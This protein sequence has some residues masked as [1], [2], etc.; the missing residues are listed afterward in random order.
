VFVTVTDA[1]NRLVANLERAD[2]RLL[3]NGAAQSITVFDNGPR[4]LRLVL[5][6]DVSASMA[7]NLTLLREG[8]EAVF[9]RLRPDDGV[10]LGT[11][12]R[13]VAI[14]PA[15]S[16]DVN[17][18]R[19]ALPAEIDRRALTPLWKALDQ[20]MIALEDAESRPVVIVFSDGRD[21]GP[22]PG[23]RPVGL[24]EVV[25]RAHRDGIM[26]YAVGLHSRGGSANSPNGLGNFMTRDDRPDPGLSAL[27]AQTGGRYFEV[28]FDPDRD[29]GTAF[30][31]AMDELHSQYLLGF[32]PPHDGQVH[33]IDVSVSRPDLTIRARRSY[34]APAP[35]GP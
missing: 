14:A 17:A 4:P 3:D 10:R 30:A 35:Q 28:D 32:T 16:S 21:S 22:S 6:L 29:L 13:T 20:A 11:F 23:D 7:P 25:S 12:G 8:S 9:K 19:S 18:L 5:L 33:A 2:F 31:T 26:V 27:A 34:E 15:F 24:A 1:H